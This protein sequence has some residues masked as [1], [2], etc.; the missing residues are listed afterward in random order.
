MS[1]FAIG[2]A[3][4]FVR[5]TVLTRYWRLTGLLYRKWE[6][7]EPGVVIDYRPE[8]P[9]PYRVRFGRDTFWVREDELG[10]GAED[11][12]EAYRSTTKKTKPRYE[13]TIRQTF[14]KRNPPHE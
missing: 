4:Y 9:L 12:V 8:T 7:Y 3:V 10:S 1:K 5:F 6:K 2:D 13:D 14:Y 11:F